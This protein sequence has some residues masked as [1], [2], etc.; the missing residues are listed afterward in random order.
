MR[1][2]LMGGGK[3]GGFL[4]RELSDLGHAVVVIEVNQLRTEKV[5]AGFAGLVVHGDGTDLQLLSSL[6]LRP[7]DFFVALT[8]V[9]EDNLVA[10]QMA[11]VA[12]KIERVLARLNSPSNRATFDALSIPVVSVTDLLVQ[13]ISHELDV[14]DLVR[15][16]LLGR[17]EVSLFELSLPG[18]FESRLVAEM[19]LPD[20]SLIVVVHRDTAVL[21]PHGQTQL[22]PGDRILILAKV[23]LEDSIREIVIG[24]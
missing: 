23:D 13:V 5:A 2:I 17:G 20:E 22:E 4:A 21:V 18:E 1:A 24:T 7:D 6:D 16:A 10:C 14:E 11:K 15:V 19:G 12:F 8:G 3:V 9:D